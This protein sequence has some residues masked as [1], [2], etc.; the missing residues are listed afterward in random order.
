MIGSSIRD[1]K[2][3]AVGAVPQELPGQEYKRAFSVLVCAPKLFGNP[4]PHEFCSSAGAHMSFC[5]RAYNV[6]EPNFGKKQVPIIK[7]TGA[8]AIKVGK[9]QSRELQ[10]EV[11][12]WITRPLVMVEA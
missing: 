7:F 5:E 12:K 3:F 2:P 4:E 9:G 11:L 6:C 1:Y 10:F 8:E